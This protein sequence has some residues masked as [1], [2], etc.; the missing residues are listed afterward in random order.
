MLA[1][2]DKV[3]RN[4]AINDAEIN[5]TE[6]WSLANYP[7]LVEMQNALD[8]RPVREFADLYEKLRVKQQ[9]VIDV[10]D[11]MLVGSEQLDQLLTETP[12]D[13]EVQDWGATPNAPS[14]T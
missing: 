1:E 7:E 12:E 3:V 4:S 8:G 13:F 11:R 14:Q 2:H 9:V 5:F 6:L 10:Q